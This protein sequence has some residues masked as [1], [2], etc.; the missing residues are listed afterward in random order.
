M[1]V[2]AIDIGSNSVHL[3]VCRIHAPGVREVLDREREMLQLGRSCFRRGAIPEAELDRAIDVLRRYRAIAEAHGVEAVLAVAT[4]A[5]RDAKNRDLFL[6]RAEREAR[7]VVRVLTGKEEGRLIYAG[8]RDALPLTLHRISV[9]DIGGGSV[10]IVVGEGRDVRSVRCLNLGV[11]RLSN[12]LR[13]RRPREIRAFEERLRAEVGPAAREVKRAGVEVAVGTSGTVLTVADLLGVRDTGGPIRLEALQDLVKRLL[14]ESPQKLTEEGV[15]PKRVDTVGP[16]AALLRI[17]ME[18][19]GLPELIPC[20]RALREGVVAD[21]A[22]RNS[23]RLEDRETEI[24]DPR[25]RSVHFLARRLGALDLH[26]RQTARLSLRLFDGLA[27]LHGLGDRDRELLE[28]AALLHDA[29]YWIGADK[30]HKH[31]YYLIRRAPLEGFTPDEVRMLALI[32]RY[33]RGA[34]PKERHKDFSKLGKEDRGRVRALSSMLRIADALDRSHAAL[35]QELDI[36]IDRKS[37]TLRVTAQGD[38]GLEL[39]AVKNRSELFRRILGREIRVQVNGK[40]KP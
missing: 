17:F 30:H 15:D 19:A 35:V 22:L 8:A 34:P 40:G 11:L 2:A 38:L 31:V 20:E 26:A 39:Y 29:G 3:V 12:R 25:R 18:E 32:A 23:G 21:Y 24:R 1:K 28:F 9:I 6:R 7:M 5:V 37:V 27:A 36:E 4:S 13:G 10:E 16:G 33:H 14:T